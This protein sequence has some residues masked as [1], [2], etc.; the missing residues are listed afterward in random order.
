MAAIEKR[1]WHCKRSGPRFESAAIPRRT[2]NRTMERYQLIFDD[3]G[4]LDR[5]VASGGM[6][7]RVG[8]AAAF[9][10]VGGLVSAFNGEVSPAKAVAIAIGAAAIC[11]F[12]W[13]RAWTRL[14]AGDPPVAPSAA[15]ALRIQQNSRPEAAY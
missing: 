13:R 1:D 15:S 5:N 7:L 12:A 4:R 9:A 11:A 10:V 8:T 2:S 6:W 14:N 3:Q